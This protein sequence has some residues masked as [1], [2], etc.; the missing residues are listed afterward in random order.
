MLFWG[1]LVILGLIVPM[2]ILFRR[3][4]GRSVQWVVLASALVVFGVLCERYVIVIPGLT[5]P[6]ELIPG[7]EVIGPGLVEGIADYSVSFIEVVQAL[8]VL[9]VI[10]FLFM[11]GLKVFE[12]LPTEARIHKPSDS[13]EA[14]T[15]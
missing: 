7:M 2:V 12:L 15:A 8:G 5:N 11:W 6:P 1:G 13:V 4:T 14:P 10:G 3:T 9:G